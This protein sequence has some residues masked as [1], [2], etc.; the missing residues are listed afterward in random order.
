M[1][2]LL[3]KILALL[4]QYLEKLNNWSTWQYTGMF[5]DFYEDLS[6]S[7][8]SDLRLAAAEILYECKEFTPYN[9]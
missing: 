9:Q 1:Y 7:Q 2:L 5:C 8:R 3:I 6:R 4:S